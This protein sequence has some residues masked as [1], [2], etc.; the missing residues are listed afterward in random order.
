MSPTNNCAAIAHLAGVKLR[1]PSFALIPEQLERRLRADGRELIRHG[2]RCRRQ[3]RVSLA[4]RADGL[5]RQRVTHVEHLEHD[6]VVVAAQIAHRAVAKVP[7]PIPARSRK[8]RR[9]ERPHGRGP[10]PQIPVD[11]RRDGHLFR[12]SVGDLD[13][14]VE[15]VRLVVLRCRF[16]ALQPPRSTRPDVHLAHWPDRAGHE[17]FLNLTALRR[18]VALVARLR[19][20]MRIFR[21]GLANQ[22][23]FPDVVGERLLTVHVFAVRERQIRWERVGVLGR[24][25]DDRIEVARAVEDAAEDHCISSLL[26]ISGPRHPRHSG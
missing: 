22:P 15:P 1:R 19:R 5:D 10:N 24:T 26:G 16:G 21:G 4:H 18:G 9:M 13:A 12:E 7:P 23:C 17:Q 6:V 25:D 14:V 8:V 11:V 2:H 20:E 3:F